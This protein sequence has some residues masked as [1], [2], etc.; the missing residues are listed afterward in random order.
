MTLRDL[1][2]AEGDDDD[3]TLVYAVPTAEVQMS[4]GIPL[5]RK[6]S[7]QSPACP[8]HDSDTLAREFLQLVPQLFGFVAG[9]MP[10]IM[11]DLDP[12]PAERLAGG[13]PA[14]RRH[15]ADAHRVL[16]RL[17]PLQRPVL[18]FVPSPA[19]ITLRPAT[20]LAIVNPMD[21]LLPHPHLVPPEAHYTALSKRALALSPLPTP[22]TTVVDTVLGPAQAADAE[23]LAFEAERM[24]APLA[25]RPLPF[26]AKLPQAL[27]GQGTF[28]VRTEAD[29][30]AALDALR[31][32]TARMLR[33][34]RPENAHLDPCCLLLQAM[35]PGEAVALSLFVTKRGRAV[36]NACCR[37]LVDA[38]G[39]WGGGFVDYREQDALR[40][41]YRE[42]AAR[43]AVYMHKLGYWGPMGADIMTDKEGR[44]VVIDMN[45][46][47]TGSH[48]L[49]ALRGHFGRRGLNV[50]V[51]F[52]PLMLKLTWE[53]FE[54]RFKEELHFGGLVVNAWV[55]M[56]D[57][58][59]SMTTVT[60]AA[61]DKEKLNEF[62][63]RV[64]AFKMEDH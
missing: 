1:Y 60:L 57:G 8:T 29:R 61:E 33:G 58:K 16:D 14:H 22:P 49:G 63:E 56:Q 19:A 2:A 26:V 28:L 38:E 36:F 42:T 11:F 15:Q 48:P 45:V 32:E 43:L 17:A 55:H 37:Q 13:T 50:A 40:E 30:A 4:A 47:V 46:R 20:R 9:K 31:P 59:T 41:E 3:I 53:E 5:S 24:L 39:N 25:A 18:T 7:Y 44:Q 10:L 27:S 35:A 52:F 34:L 23:L 21:C 6:F 54:R 12:D 62:V 64:R 51:L